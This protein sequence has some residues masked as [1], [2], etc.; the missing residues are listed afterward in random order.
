MSET[1]LQPEE[2][3]TPEIEGLFNAGVHFAYKKTRRHPKMRPFIAGVKSNVEIF[4]LD[5]VEECIVAACAYIGHLGETKKVV[6][7]V[8]TKPAADTTITAIGNELKQP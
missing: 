7:W 4:H 5:K 2:Q 1:T 3:I 8:G 6:M